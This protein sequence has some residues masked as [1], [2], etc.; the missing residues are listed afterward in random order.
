MATTADRPHPPRPE[1]H[2]SEARGPEARE[3][4]ARESEMCEPEVREQRG[5]LLDRISDW[6][7]FPLAVLALVML[8]LLLLELAVDLPTTWAGRVGQAQTAIWAIFVAAFVVELLVAPSK[9]DYLR[10]NWLTAIS[11]ALPALRAVRILRAARAL[12][13]LSLVRILTTVNRGTRALGHVV[14]RGQLG[15]VLTVTVLVTVTASAGAYYFDRGEPGA[16][17][18]TPGDALWWGATMVTTISS[19]LEVVTLEG[20]IISLLLRVFALA[21]SGYLTA[22]IAV[23]LLGGTPS[24]NTPSSGTPGDDAADQQP[25]QQ[26]GQHA[27]QLTRPAASQDEMRQLREQVARLERLLERHAAD[28]DRRA[29]RAPVDATSARESPRSAGTDRAVGRPGQGAMREE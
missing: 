12:R 21:V 9:L 8:V 26:A 3:P 28:H 17:I 19:P 10:K 11:V 16:Q 24:D 6:L 29:D 4:E 14:R 1:M 23:F 7:D 2:E 5:E 22:I 25:T 13:G 18:R 15:Y 20:R 27:G